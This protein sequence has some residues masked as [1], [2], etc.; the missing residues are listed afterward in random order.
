MKV[1]QHMLSC[2]LCSEVVEGRSKCEDLDDV[3][4]IIETLKEEF[5]KKL[6]QLGD[7]DE[8]R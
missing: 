6:Y 3:P 4:R 1:Q 5:K 2:E 8:F 7:D